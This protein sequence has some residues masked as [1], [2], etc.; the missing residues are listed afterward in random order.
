[1]KL[2]IRLA[3]SFLTT[4]T[5]GLAL[6][7]EN[8]GSPDHFR[9]TERVLQ[10]DLPN[11]STNLTPGT[12]APWNADVM[13]NAW[14]L[15]FDS[16][17]I[18]FQQH[19]QAD[20]G[21]E[22]WLQHKEA[23]RLSAWDQARSGFWDGADVYIYRI[24]SGVMNLLR[25]TKVSKSSIGNDPVTNARTEEKIWFADKGPAVKSGDFYVLRM[26]RDT[27]PTQIRKEILQGSET[28]ALSGY[29]KTTGKAVWSFDRANVAPEGGSKASLRLDIKEATPEEPSGPW[30]WFVTNGKTPNEGVVRFKEGKKYRA[31]LWLKQEGMADPRVKLQF[32]TVLR[33]TVEASGEWKKFEF[34]LPV[35]NP[36]LPYATSQNDGTRMWIAGVSPG[37]LWIDN[38]IIYQTDIPPFAM[39]R[40]EVETLKKFKPHTLRVWGG[41][42]APTLE[43]W[44]SKGFE[45]PTMMSGYG[46]SGSPVMVSLGEALE[47]CREV[48]A[49]PWL[50]VNPWFTAEENAGLMEYLAAPA[51]QGLGK[52]RAQHGHPEPWTKTFRKIYI[53]S[54]NEAWNQIMRYAMPSHPERYAAVADRQFREFKASPFFVRDNFEFIANG[55]DNSMKPDGWTRR[56]ALASKEADRVDI[57]YYFGGWEKNATAPSGEDAAKDEVYQDKLFGTALEFGPKVVDFSMCDPQFVRHFAGVL[58]K[59]PELLAS[60]LSAIGAPKTKFKPEQL[61][62]TDIGALWALDTE[63]PNGLRGLVATRRATLEFP[64]MHAAFRA[65]AKDPSLQPQTVEALALAEPQNL[66]ELADGLI[67]LNAPSRLL[68]FFKAHPESVKKWAETLEGRPREDLEAFIAKPEKLTYNITN[69][70]KR[71]L[72][73]KVLELAAAGDPAFLA[74][75]KKE[76]TPDVIRG[77][78]THHVNYVMAA[79]FRHAPERR[80]DHLMQA[81]KADPAFASSALK[82]ISADPK[83]FQAE[84]A[85]MAELLSADIAGLFGRGET[86]KPE[87]DSKLIMLALP[88]DVRTELW[89]RVRDSGLPSI[90]DDNA[91]LLMSAML[92]AQLG[93]T[94]PA[95]ALASDSVFIEKLERRIGDGIPVPFLTAAGSNAEVGDKLLRLLAQ[96]PSLTAKKLAVYEGGPGYSLPGPGKSSSEEDENIGKSLALGTATLD[97]SMQFLAAGAAPVAYYKYRTGSYWSSHNNPKDRVPYPTWLALEMKNTLCP[98][99]LLVVEEVKVR[100]QD[101]PDKEV[102]KT[103]NDGK[104]SKA[105]VKGRAGV[106]M[107]VC[108]AF[109]DG[110]RLSVMLIN[111][112]LSEPTTVTLDIPQGFSGPTRQYALTHPDPKAHNRFEEN[113]KVLESEGPPFKSGMEV[114]VP[115]ASVVVLAGNK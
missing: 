114:V 35:D 24:E 8:Q 104:G 86:F 72:Q 112:S 32:G 27:M 37:T 26:E 75:L 3:A 49:D 65:M 18:Q 38:F 33:T 41:L 73:A 21:G 78:M 62:A 31:Q 54:A 100:R 84:G 30:H 82:K 76:V 97:A 36:E 61:T 81:M 79:T 63:F 99:D 70:L 89:Q 102:I 88:A 96:D 107:A 60:G 85:A 58:G 56:V 46:K 77:H 16:G 83:A 95:E 43:Y 106:P 28:A 25:K 103:S 113:V 111:R 55:W 45:Q 13:V 94:K 34:D 6:A 108:Y 40:D 12:F 87:D 14:S 105:K 42:D 4:A 44:L 59:N 115:P 98:G 47:V 110:G 15:L 17:P 7:A 20:D 90:S 52:L 51:D 109:R 93:D 50:I 80:V 48:G 9:I 91:R 5:A 19:G 69:E 11:F 1:M 2:P 92:A 53:E 57:A 22:D 29:C 66:P 101:I 74:A 68:P 64:I 67:D 71:R 10:K 23:P 39:M